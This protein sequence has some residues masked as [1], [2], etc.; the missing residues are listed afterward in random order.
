MKTAEAVVFDFNGTL[1]FDYRENK[2]A[3]NIVSLKYRNREFFSDEY[4]AMMGMTDSMCVRHMLPSVK[5]EDIERIA[6]EKE[7]IYL[8]LCRERGLALEKDAVILIKRLNSDGIK[9]LIASSA[10][11]GNMEWYK[12][13]LG[14]LDLFRK[15][16]IIAGMENMK[17]KPSPDIFRYALSKAGVKGENALLFEDSPNGLRAGLATPFNKV[18]CIS[19]PSF[20]DTIQKTLTSVIDWKYTLDNYREI[21]TLNENKKS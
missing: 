9:T 14:L 1:Y 10:P 5:E 20:D 4:D 15:E 8:S 17:S 18:Y 12:K 16:Y 6:D 2:D 13:N 19:S 11:K 21:I 3:W 7:E